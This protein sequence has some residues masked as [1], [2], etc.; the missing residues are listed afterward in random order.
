MT[1]RSEPFRIRATLSI[2]IDGADALEIAAHRRRLEE[3]LTQVRM[4]YGT[5]NLDVKPRRPRTKP[6][7]PTPPKLEPGFEIVRA[8]YGA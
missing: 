6:R 3:V 7:A 4:S 5:A 2:D 1:S 8:R